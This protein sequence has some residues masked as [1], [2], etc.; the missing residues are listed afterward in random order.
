[1]SKFK[2]ILNSFQLKDS[3]N[4]KVWENADDPEQAK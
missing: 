4:P 1:M 2:E 3:L